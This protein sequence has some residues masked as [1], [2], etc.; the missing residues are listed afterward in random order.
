M[1]T[2]LFRRHLG[3]EQR[4]LARKQ[5]AGLY[6]H[7]K[8]HE[9]QELTHLVPVGRG[10]LGLQL[11]EVGG[12]DLEQRHLEKV[13]LLL[14]DERQQQ[15]ERPLVDVQIEFESSQYRL[16]NG[17]PTK[18]RCHTAAMAPWRSDPSGP[19]RA[20]KMNMKIMNA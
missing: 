1:V 13:D 14:E 8:T 17:D 5:Q 9:Q 19:L 4:F 10:P 2:G 16:D 11:V 15:V 20:M 18:I 7:Q 12:D 6:L 3:L